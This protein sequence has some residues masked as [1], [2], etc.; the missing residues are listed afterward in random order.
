M[1]LAAQT[2]AWRAGCRRDQQTPVFKQ[3][4]FGLHFS[5]T[6]FFMEVVSTYHLKGHLH[7][8]SM[9]GPSFTRVTHNRKSPAQR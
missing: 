5:H 2:L 7:N 3:T 6:L 1:D 4:I 8:C 9:S